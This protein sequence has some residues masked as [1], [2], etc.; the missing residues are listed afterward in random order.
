MYCSTC[1]GTIAQG[2]SYCKH[3]GAKIIRDDSVDQ[4]SELRPGSLV[5][6]MMATFIFGLVAIAMLAGV[7]RVMVGLPTMHVVGIMALPFLT[8]FVME[9]VFI[10][11]LLRRTENRQITNGAELTRVQ[12]TNELD[13]ARAQSLPEG[14]ASV[15]EH[16]TRAFE[17]VIR[18]KG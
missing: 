16:T 4:S 9:A 8:M 14:M 10:R 18:T 13:A 7:L 17:P 5:F 1:G 11:L 3:C 2:L 12:A 15:T 6:A